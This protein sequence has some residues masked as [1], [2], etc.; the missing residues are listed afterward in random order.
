MLSHVFSNNPNTNTNININPRKL[1]RRPHYHCN[2]F[3]IIVTM[4]SISSKM[5]LGGSRQFS[6]VHA[7]VP[8]SSRQ[9]LSRNISNAAAASSSSSSIIHHHHPYHHQRSS[10]RSM[11]SWWS[12]SLPPKTRPR[13]SKTWT[14]M[15]TVASTTTSTWTGWLASRPSRSGPPWP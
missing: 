2:I 3:I 12:G 4:L 6:L 1:C 9:N 11:R 13:R 14:R 8:N 15:A 7:F 10:T 5:L